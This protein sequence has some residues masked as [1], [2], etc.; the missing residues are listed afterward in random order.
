MRAA[1]SM[2]VHFGILM[3]L[4]E[5]HQRL[6]RPGIVIEDRY[7]DDARLDHRLGLL[8]GRFDRF[9]SASMSSGLIRSGSNLI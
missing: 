6:A 2:S 7:L 1:Y 8:G 9:S 3:A 5:A 4:A